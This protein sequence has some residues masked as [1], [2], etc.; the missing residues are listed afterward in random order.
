MRII[1]RV[2]FPLQELLGPFL[3]EPRFFCLC[4]LLL[5]FFLY[6][7]QFDE[8]DKLS[9][10]CLVFAKVDVFV[11]VE[12]VDCNQCARFGNFVSLH[13]LAVSVVRDG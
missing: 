11:A 2:L 7:Q 4:S 10:L 5:L 8:S 13:K 12:D 9:Q 3:S 1:D 6:S